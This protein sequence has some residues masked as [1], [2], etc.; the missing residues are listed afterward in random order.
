MMGLKFKLGKSRKLLYA[1]KSGVKGAARIIIQCRL[2]GS[3]G[4]D[5]EK[6]I[7]TPKGHDLI[8]Q[9]EM[10]NSL[11]EQALEKICVSNL[12]EKIDWW[13]KSE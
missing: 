4:I 7:L 10:I 12:G 9:L 13:D 5:Y 8:K 11:I 3:I 2:D 1:A 6:P